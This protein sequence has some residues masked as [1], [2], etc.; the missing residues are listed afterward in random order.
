V[1]D[2]QDHGSRAELVK[3]L[4]DAGIGVDTVMLRRRLED[5][6]LGLVEEWR[7]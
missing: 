2:L 5:A 1:L 6:F 4:V 7:S 3:S